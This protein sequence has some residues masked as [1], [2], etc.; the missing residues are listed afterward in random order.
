MTFNNSDRSMKRSREIGSLKLQ[1][2]AQAAKV[3]KLRREANKLANLVRSLQHR[4]NK[5][6]AERD[7]EVSRKRES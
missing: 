6:E 1:I 7:E 4:L 2:K 5:L 3:Q